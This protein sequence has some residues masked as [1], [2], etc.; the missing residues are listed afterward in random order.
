ML[1]RQK[2]GKK[3]APQAA[4]PA[5]TQAPAGDGT[6]AFPNVRHIIAV[7]SGKGGVGKSTV[8][9]NLAAAWQR[10]GW[11]VGLMDADIY[12]PSVPTLTG[13]DG[14][15]DLTED[16]RIAPMD[17]DGIRTMSIGNMT[18]PGQALVWR[19]PM[20][21][22]ALMQMLRDVEW[23]SLDALIIDL[24]PGTGDVQLTLSQRLKLT[25]AVI[26][27]TPQD[28]ALIDARRAMAMFERVAVP[29]LGL[30]ENM[31][32]FCCPSCGHESHIFGHGGAASEAE[33]Q[34]LPFL[35]EVPL[36]MPLRELADQGKSIVR[37]LPE[38][39]ATESMMAVAST[40]QAALDDPA[41]TTRKPPNIVWR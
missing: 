27:S 37:E 22:G 15:P 20:V 28:L 17:A 12:G 34:G 35:G 3:P 31:S 14:R 13:M 4:Q 7:G 23:G 16:K 19:G 26:V 29:V 38:D 25:G 40:L 18:K 10:L 2:A 33:A 39:P 8:A 21:Q 36:T 32:V 41:R 9:M 30:I 11:T 5:S 24:P 1:T 6:L